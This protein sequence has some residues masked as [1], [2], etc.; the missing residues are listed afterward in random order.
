VS[1]DTLLAVVQT[2]SSKTPRSF[3][4]LNLATGRSMLKPTVRMHF[5]THVPVMHAKC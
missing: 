1:G 3:V 4:A 5:Q 2:T